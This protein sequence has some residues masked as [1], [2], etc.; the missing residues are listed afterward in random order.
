MDSTT[1]YAENNY[2]G[3]LTQS[4]LTSNNPYNT[5]KIKGLPPGPIANPGELA[6]RSALHP[7]Q[8]PWNYFVSMPNGQTKFAT[9]EQ[10]FQQLLAEYHAAGGTA[11]G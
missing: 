6:L 3:P 4:Q 9:T 1:R 11:G 7:D 5:R 2:E 10:E 8:G